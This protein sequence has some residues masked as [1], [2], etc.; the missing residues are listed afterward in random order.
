MRAVRSVHIRISAAR[1]AAPRPAPAR[2]APGGGTWMCTA[3]ATAARA[4]GLGEAAGLTRARRAA[5]PGR[6]AAPAE[7]NAIA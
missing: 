3:P 1:R 6:A 5:L 2:N 7:R 4:A